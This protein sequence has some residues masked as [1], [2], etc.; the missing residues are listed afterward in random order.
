MRES[1]DC[2]LLVRGQVFGY[3][4]LPGLNTV[5]SSNSCAFKVRRYPYHYDSEPQW[6]KVT[7]RIPRKTISEML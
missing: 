5:F 1:E 6:P 3:L 4:M 7:M 2:V